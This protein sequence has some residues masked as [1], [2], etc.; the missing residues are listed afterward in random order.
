LGTLDSRHE[1][2]AGGRS[3]P[4]ERGFRDDSNSNIAGL[5]GGLNGAPG[6]EE[7]L[8]AP[9]EE[10]LGERLDGNRHTGQ[11]GIAAGDV[12]ARCDGEARTNLP[13]GLGIRVDSTVREMESVNGTGVGLE[14]LQQGP[15]ERNV[16]AHVILLVQLNAPGDGGRDHGLRTRGAHATISR[17]GGLPTKAALGGN[18]L[19]DGRRFLDRF[20]DGRDNLR[21]E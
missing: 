7:L 16:K 13:S 14:Q 4:L 10:V 15:R 17:I 6:E 3:R 9:L 11:N 5:R 1:G 20:G 18:A 21:N 2:I 12:V 19:L 8:K